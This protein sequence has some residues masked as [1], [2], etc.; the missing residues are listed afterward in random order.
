MDIMSVFDGV[1]S[2]TKD[3]I[4]TALEYWDSL[5]DDRKK[6]LV[7]CVAAAAVVI[8]VAS[9]AYCLGKSKGKKL[10]FDEEDF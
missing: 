5:S 8:F 10:A 6:L 7:G 2:F 3:T 1:V 9:I 4:D